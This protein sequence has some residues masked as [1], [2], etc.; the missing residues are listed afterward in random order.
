MESA[1]IVKKIRSQIGRPDPEVKCLFSIT[2]EYRTIWSLRTKIRFTTIPEIKQSKIKQSKIKPNRC[3]AIQR[4]TECK[5][6]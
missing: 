2:I 5:S 4:E 6:T 3:D 1:L